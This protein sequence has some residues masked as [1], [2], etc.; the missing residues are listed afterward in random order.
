MSRSSINN[1]SSPN[2]RKS[3][4]IVRKQSKSPNRRGN[5]STSRRQSVTS[6]VRKQKI[7][8]PNKEEYK[9]GVMSGQDKEITGRNKD[10]SEDEESDN[11]NYCSDQSEIN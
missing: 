4:A 1:N 2:K 6:P 9:G 7:V 3:T 8:S 5:R 11:T 10:A